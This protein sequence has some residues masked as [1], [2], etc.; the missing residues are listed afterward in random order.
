M[1]Q[2]TNIL[3][4]LLFALY[5][6]MNNSISL[7]WCKSNHWL[8]TYVL[9]S[10]CKSENT[11]YRSLPGTN[12]LSLIRPESWFRQE[13]FKPAGSWSSDGSKKNFYYTC[14]WRECISNKSTTIA[15]NHL[16][17]S[18]SPS[19]KNRGTKRTLVCM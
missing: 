5:L 17:H 6:L 7:Q 19:L 3:D 11:K 4:V 10:T 12:A 9:E 14:T 18:P 13:A 2:S 8:A 16:W 15:Q 1:Y